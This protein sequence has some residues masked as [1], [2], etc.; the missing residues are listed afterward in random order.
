M[1]PKKTFYVWKC[2]NCEHRNKEVFNFH[3]EMDKNYTT[4]W[5]C[6]GCGSENFIKINFR[7]YPITEKRSEEYYARGY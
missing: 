2:A 5:H 7:V 6:S 1:N 4:T 3:W